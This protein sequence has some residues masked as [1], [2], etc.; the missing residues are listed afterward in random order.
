MS[1]DVLRSLRHDNDV[2]CSNYVCPFGFNFFLPPYQPTIQPHDTHTHRPALSEKVFRISLVEMTKKG[3]RWIKWFGPPTCDIIFGCIIYGRSLKASKSFC[4][5]PMNA[6]WEGGIITITGALKA[7]R[8]QEKKSA[9]RLKH[10][11]DGVAGWQHP[12]LRVYSPNWRLIKISIP[13]W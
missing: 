1:L 8:Q 6:A 3:F 13:N 7:L 5:L 2:I 11:W 12:R 9:G 10:S 4:C